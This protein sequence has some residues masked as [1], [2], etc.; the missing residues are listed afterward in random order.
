MD[1]SE[2]KSELQKMNDELKNSKMKIRIY[3]FIFLICCIAFIET[4][5]YVNQAP[6]LF[7]LIIGTLSFLLTEK[8]K[9]KRL[10]TI[11]KIEML[12]KI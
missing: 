8:E 11:N 1:I 4:I 7:S 9:K 10:Q 2:L 6:L 12:E 3:T 5:F